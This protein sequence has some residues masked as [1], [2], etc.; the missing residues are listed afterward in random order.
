[1]STNALQTTLDDL[2]RQHR[3]AV[4]RQQ[5]LEQQLRTAQESMS[6]LGF[7]QLGKKMLLKAEIDSINSKLNANRQLQQSLTGRIAAAGAQ[8]EAAMAEAA[9]AVEAAAPVIN[10][11]VSAPDVPAAEAAAPVIAMPA[12]AEAAEKAVAPV[13]TLPE[14][15]LPPAAENTPAPVLEAPAPRKPRAAAAR[16]AIPRAPR[17]AVD[18]SLPPEEQLTQ[19]LHHLEGFY[20]E[21]QFFSPEVLTAETRALL[22]ALAEGSGCTPADLPG[23]AG[24]HPRPGPRPARSGHPR[25]RR[26]ARRPAAQADRR[27]GPPGPPLHR[28]HHRPQHPA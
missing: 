23:L 3:A 18:T 20:P 24:H 12:P 6:K 8:L 21:H 9:P 10:A 27:A 1:M 15:E 22:A 28:P 5:D 17:L 19:L 25:P 2:N 7:M 11:P 16:T 26:R 14:A 13:P 4:R